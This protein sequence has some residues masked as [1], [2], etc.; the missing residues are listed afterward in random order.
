MYAKTYIRIPYK[1]I[2]READDN[3][4]LGNLNADGETIFVKADVKEIV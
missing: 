1:N 2:V 4:L 3:R